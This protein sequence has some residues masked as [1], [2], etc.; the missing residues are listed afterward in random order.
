VSR[1]SPPVSR[2][3]PRAGVGSTDPILDAGDRAPASASARASAGQVLEI[4]LYQ[5]AEPRRDLVR[6]SEGRPTR[7][8]ALNLT[9]ESEF[10]AFQ[11]FLDL[12]LKRSDLGKVTV[13]PGVDQVFHGLHG[14]L[15]IVHVPP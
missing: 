6:A 5:L 2:P 9:S 7:S 4:F 3:S 13:R 1:P 11:T 12:L 10:Q 15:K 8:L 14:A